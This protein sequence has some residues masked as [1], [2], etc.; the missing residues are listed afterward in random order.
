MPSHGWRIAST[1][2]VAT[3]ASPT[4]IAAVIRVIGGI[5]DRGR[6]VPVS[7]VIGSGG[8]WQEASFLGTSVI[9]PVQGIPQDRGGILACHPRF[10]R[11]SFAKEANSFPHIS[12]DCPPLDWFSA[13]GTPPSRV[14]MSW[15]AVWWLARSRL[16]PHP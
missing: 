12:P 6:K 4:A 8:K 16:C 2:T 13:R 3:T 15:G 5:P 1:V 7:L 14:P 11:A 9:S 10:R